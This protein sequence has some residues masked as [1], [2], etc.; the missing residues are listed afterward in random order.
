[1]SRPPGRMKVALFID[2][3]G[4]KCLLFLNR[5]STINET[6]VPLCHL[7]GLISVKEEYSIFVH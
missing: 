5:D 2:V 3:K 4:L 1:M 7:T 6:A